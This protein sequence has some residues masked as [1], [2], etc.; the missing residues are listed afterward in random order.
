MKIKSKRSTRVCIYDNINKIVKCKRSQE[1][2]VGFV[3]IIVLVVIIA[4]VFLGIMLRKQVEVG[5]ELKIEDFLQAL[6]KVTTE[7]AA[8]YEPNYL[9]IQ[10][11][12]KSCLKGDKCFNGKESC[13][14]LNETLARLLED[15]WQVSQ[16]S[17]VSSYKLSVEYEGEVKLN[18][19]K[20]KCVGSLSMGWVPI[21][22]SGGNIDLK[23]EICERN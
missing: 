22:Y 18:L 15:S 4:V 8:S 11:L 16:E 6:S 5:S 1:E 14:V 13:L 19:E 12:I 21:A 10:A 17:Y 20:G 9:D 7:C 3:L 2:M 23:I